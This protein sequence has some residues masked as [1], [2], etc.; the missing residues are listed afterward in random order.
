MNGLWKE[1]LSGWNN[2]DQ[3]RKSQTRKDTLRDKGRF[4]LK[5]HNWTNSPKKDKNIFRTET[6][7]ILL[8]KSKTR[9][10]GKYG[11]VV[12]ADISIPLFEDGNAVKSDWGGD[13]TY[14]KTLYVYRDH[15]NSVWREEESQ[16]TIREFLD[17]NYYQSRR[18]EVYQQHKTN[19]SVELDWQTIV[20]SNNKIRTEEFS[21]YNEHDFIYNKPLPSWKRW[22]FY[23]NG[24]RSTVGQMI[25]T[26]KER[27]LLK[28]YISNGDWDKDVKVKYE[29]IY[30]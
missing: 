4:I 6:E 13:K 29:V 11:D 20:D 19:R 30:F 24:K 21:H 8:Y 2:K 15:N 25:S 26:R 22:T 9:F 28:Q 16:K 3:K 12:K 7:E 10:V 23:N 1:N 17:L 14:S 5:T 18:F 27:T